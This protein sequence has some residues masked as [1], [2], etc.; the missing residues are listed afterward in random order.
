MET[1]RMILMMAMLSFGF[2]CGLGYDFIQTAARQLA[3][4]YY[5]KHFI[6]FT[7][8]R[9]IESVKEWDELERRIAE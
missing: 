9:Y 3:N 5:E 7:F 2:V 4:R 1:D 6:P 8:K